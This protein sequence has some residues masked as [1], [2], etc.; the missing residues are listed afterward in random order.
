MGR[1]G[2]VGAVPAYPFN[3]R[4][5]EIPRALEARFFAPQMLDGEDITA[6]QARIAGLVSGEIIPRL[7]TLHRHL[8]D[9]DVAEAELDDGA[10][11]TA[12]EIDELAHLVLSPDPHVAAAYV[13]ALRERG[14]HMETLF[15]E[16]LEPAA[17]HLGD[18]WERDECDF[19][20]VTLGVGRLQKLL[21]VF[22]C[23]HDIPAFDSK[24]A[25]LMLTVPGEQHGF[26]ISM[27]TKFL[28][29]GGWQ[30]ASL[31]EAALATLGRAVRERW[32]AAAGVTLSN[33]AN[34]D[35]VR[36]AIA[37]IRKASQNPAIGVMVGGPVFNR[38]P[39]LVAQVGADG[40]A[41]SA[42]TAVLMAQKL[43]DL[44]MGGPAGRRG[45]LN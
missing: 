43:F 8:A 34:L 16:L 22:N 21:A 28:E 19:I 23:T 6:R 25:V 15:V 18:M 10:H 36:D 17:R 32:F 33:D 40:T 29:A 24:R 26:G 1:L 5:V 31:P 35:K 11:P 30:V 14:L 4:P 37:A 3:L 13:V 12:S 20:D 7:V 38:D 44:G 41:A 45:A 39:G 2:V 42:P 27:V 9:G